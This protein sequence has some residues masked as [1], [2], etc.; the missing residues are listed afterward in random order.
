MGNAPSVAGPDRGRSHAIRDVE[1]DDQLVGQR[2]VRSNALAVD[3]ETEPADSQ[4]SLQSN[5]KSN[6][7]DVP[8]SSP[9]HTIFRRLWTKVHKI[10]YECMGVIT[11]C[12][13]FFRSSISCSN[14]Q[15]F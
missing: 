7:L 8:E 13:A 14:L 1:S 15:I 12:N 2:P 9:S 5:R 4:T 6:D 10:W 11:V 3:R